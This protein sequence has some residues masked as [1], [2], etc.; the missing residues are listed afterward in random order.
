[1]RN[2]KNRIGTWIGIVALMLA[3]EAGALTAPFT[4]S[5][6]TSVSGWESSAN[7]PLAF[8]ASGGA[9]GGGYASGSY[10]YFNY[11]SGFGAGPIVLRASFADTPS[12][13]AFIG[14]WIAGAVGTVTA[15]VRHDAPEALAFNLRLAQP[16]NFPGAFFAGSVLVPAN[17]WT[18]VSW[19]LDP[20]APNCT[21]E[22]ISCA[23]ALTNIG[24]LQIGTNAPAGLIDDDVAYTI[25]VDQVSLSV[26]PEP[27]TALL[28]GLGLGG[29]AATGRR[30]PR[31]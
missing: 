18:Q 13:G 20:S 2:R 16:A 11:A 22:T 5:F 10:N 8:I 14:D 23:A 29:L 12:G 17:V 24:T 6:D 27:G 1:M 21:P 31:I 30:G 9:D 15:M 26:V 25:D 19:S 28:F 3:S 7:A 4:E